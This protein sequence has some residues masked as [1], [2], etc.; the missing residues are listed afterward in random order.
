MPLAIPEQ[1]IDHARIRFINDCDGSEITSSVL[2]PLAAG[3][4][5]VSGMAL[6][7]PDPSGTATTVTPGT[8]ALTTPNS[9]PVPG[10]STCGS[11]ERDYTP[12]RVELRLAGRPD[13]DLSNSVLCTT[14]QNTT[15]ADCYPAISQIRVYNDSG[16]LIGDRPQIRDVS[17]SPSGTRPCAPDVYYARSSAT[18]DCTFDASVFMDWGSRPAGADATFSATIQVGSGAARDL[19]GPTPQ[20]PWTGF[21]VPIGALG[22]D[23]VRVSWKYELRSGSWGPLSG[24][25][26]PAPC[27]QQG[28]TTVQQANLADDPTGSEASPSD[29]VGAVKLTAGPSVTSDEVHSALTN[30][31]LSPFVTVGL[32]TVFQPGDWSVLRLKQGNKN[33]SVICDPYWSQPGTGDAT[34]A[35]FSVANPRTPRTTRRATGP[36]G[37]QLPRRVQRTTSCRRPAHGPI[38]PTPTRRG[39]VSCSTRTAMNRRRLTG[40]LSRRATAQR[41]SWTRNP[42][43]AQRPLACPRATRAGMT[44]TTSESATRLPSTTR[45]S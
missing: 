7:G 6:W 22:P 38:R 2:K 20:G 26:S 36:G 35:F 9:V 40:L 41:P 34:A 29:I 18:P 19:T 8:I 39:A 5:T 37:R 11:S 21:Q 25:T 17:L 27:V 45:E 32:R 15:S 23:N 24:C 42:R 44:R 12:I 28:T 33:V 10:T 4:Q 31:T 30:T 14:L 43:M 3:S 16:G 1:S 13:I